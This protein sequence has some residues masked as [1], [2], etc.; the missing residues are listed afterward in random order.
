M[1]ILVP[2]SWSWVQATVLLLFFPKGTL[3][4]SIIHHSECP[5]RVDNEALYNLCRRALDI[6]RPTYP[7]LSRVIGQMVSSL[8]FDVALNVDFTE[9]Q[10]NLVPY[11]RIHFP[12][13]SYAPV[14]NAEVW[15]RF[16]AS[17]RLT[18][19]GRQHAWTTAS[20]CPTI[21]NCPAD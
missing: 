16:S 3:N 10:T 21:W 13:C 5:F 8:R 2:P 19:S 20:R 7:N 12:I 18:V 1:S 4:G 17:A 9:F 11:A 14:V 6:D 15:S